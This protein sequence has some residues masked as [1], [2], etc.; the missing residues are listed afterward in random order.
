MMAGKYYLMNLPAIITRPIVVLS[1]GR[2]GSMLLTHNI[3]QLL[4][5]DL[6]TL[7][8]SNSNLQ[9]PSILPNKTPI[10]THMLVSKSFFKDY[11]QIYNLRYDP[12]ETILS[13]ILADTFKHYH[14]FTNQDLVTHNS[15]EFVE[16]Q[17]LDKMCQ[18]FIEWHVHYGTQL[19]PDDYV[20][21]YEKYV[22]T[23]SNRSSAYQPLYTNKNCLLINYDQ[24]R[25]FIIDNYLD[26]MLTSIDPFLQHQNPFDIYQ[27]L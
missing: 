16:W 24:V 10:H 22:D 5:A 6:V 27:T 17:C 23:I 25:K 19:L 11:T 18:R 7:H 4:N 26:C 13:K 14:Q 12:V 3:G 20:V 21:V 15:F 2:S 9:M 8:V 1:Y